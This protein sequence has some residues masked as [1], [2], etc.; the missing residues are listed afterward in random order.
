MASGVRRRRWPLMI[1]SDVMPA[2][3]LVSTPIV[4]AFDALTRVQL[5]A[6]A[7][8]ASALTVLFNVAQI[9]ILPALVSREDL[10]EANSKTSPT[11]SISEIGAFGI[12]AAP[13][14]CVRW[15]ASRA[16]SSRG[17]VKSSASGLRWV[18][19]AP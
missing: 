6:V 4:A 17:W 11:Q 9:S 18:W 2:S 15:H 8:V 19:A 16:F 10:L 3:V 12:G 7:L 14:S 5:Y 1:A 13:S